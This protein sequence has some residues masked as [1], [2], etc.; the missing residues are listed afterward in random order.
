MC[1]CVVNL[2]R[3][4]SGSISNKSRNSSIKNRNYINSSSSSRNSRSKARFCCNLFV[5]VMLHEHGEVIERD[6][7][8][9]DKVPRLPQT[10]EKKEKWSKK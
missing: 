5:A 9:D 6:P 1:T 3:K 4:G 8:I 2:L 7:S 10:H